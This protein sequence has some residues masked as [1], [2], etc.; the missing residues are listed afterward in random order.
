[1]DLVSCPTPP[2]VHDDCLESWQ[3]IGAGGF[4]QIHRAKHKK[5]GMDVAIKILHD[6]DGSNSYLLREA[7]LMRHGGNPNV[8][9]ILGVY[10]SQ[11]QGDRS[12]IQMGLVMEYMERGSLADLQMALNGSPPW[13]LTFRIINQI[14]LG[15][16]FLHQLEPPLLHLDLKPSNVLLDDSLNAKLTDFGLSKIAKS[17]S[18]VIEEEDEAVAG[19]TSYMPP[20]AFRSSQYVP[21]FS[22]DVYSYGILLWSVITGKQPYIVKFSSLVRFRVREGDRPDLTSLDSSQADGLGDLIDLMKRCWDS[23]PEKR[24]SFMDCIEVTKNVYELHKQHVPDAV[25]SVLKQLENKD[26]NSSSFASLCTHPQTENGLKEHTDPIVKTHI[27]TQ[28]MGPIPTASGAGTFA[29]SRS[30]ILPGMYCKPATSAPPINCRPLNTLR[31]NSVPS[32]VS[33]C[34]SNVKGVQ[35]G[36]NNYMNVNMQGTRQRQ[37]HPTAPSGTRQPSKRQQNPPNIKS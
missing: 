10:K 34:L 18:K 35:I 20:E 12:A 22:S 14:A 33:I 27:P 17:T 29:Q 30:P 11:V 6:N 24:P 19:T 25:H 2:V 23:D 13:A 15:M 21:T 37:R 7:D 28:E 3:Q 4:G 8:L 16:N 36:N 9:R 26:K 32:T 31:Q 1:M 5:W